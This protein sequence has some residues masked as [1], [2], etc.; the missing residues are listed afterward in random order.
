[1]REVL[2]ANILTI[3]GQLI[4][5]YSSTRKQKNQILIFQI[6][7]MA[8]MSCGSLL[9][10]GYS[11][12]V[13]DAVAILRNL[14]SIFSISFKG[15]PIFF[16]VLSLVLGFLFNNMGFIGYLPM[17]ANVGQSIFV[18]NKNTTTRQLQL[19]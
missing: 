18:L 7:A 4:T 3:I 9:L 11:A 14:F 13:M 15:L 17:I 5:F 19:V 2:Y 16:I 12:I 10:K 6:V 1:M 8:V